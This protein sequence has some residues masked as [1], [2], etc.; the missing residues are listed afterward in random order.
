MASS[1]GILFLFDPFNSPDFRSQIADGNDPQLEKPVMDQQGVILSEMKIRIARLLKME[2]IDQIETPLAVLIGK[3]DAW[4]HLLGSKALRQPVCA[5]RL[6]LDAVH[7][8]SVRVREFMKKTCPAIVANAESISRRVMFFP[9]SSFGHAPV[10]L[11]RGDYVP[12]P[13]QLKPF[14]VETPMLWVLSRVEPKL[15]PSFSLQAA[16]A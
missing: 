9:V 7:D 2:L 8:N 16:K 1:A 4:L 10:R 13:R 11:A 6:D 14:Q 12:D 15:V 3:C 5:G